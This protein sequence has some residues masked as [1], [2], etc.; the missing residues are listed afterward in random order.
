MSAALSAAR[1]LTTG[2]LIA[3]TAATVVIGVHLANDRAAALSSTRTSQVSAQAPQTT[4]R[5]RSERSGDD[6]G[7]VLGQLF[8]GSSGSS[9]QS[10][11]SSGVSGGSQTRTSGS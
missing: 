10:G 6:S 1:A 7:G 5:T 11:V 9:G 3:S 2:T 4:T 8:Q